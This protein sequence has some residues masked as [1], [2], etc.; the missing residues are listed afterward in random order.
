[1]LLCLLALAGASTLLCAAAESENKPFCSWTCAVFTLQWPGAFC[2]SLDDTSL[3][4]LLPDVNSWLIHGLW[5]QKIQQCCRCWNMFASDV[6]DIRGPL[7]EKWPSLLTSRSSLRF[8]KDEWEKHGACAGCVEGLNSP[9]AYF[10][11]CLKLRQRFDLQKALEDA[12]VTPSCQRPYKLAEVQKALLPLAGGDKMEIQ[13]IKDHQEREVWFQ[14]KIQLS[15]NMSLGCPHDSGGGGSSGG[16]HHDGKDGG[17]SSGGHPCP[18]GEAF[19]YV[20]I[21]H[22]HPLRPCG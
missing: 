17:S 15:R 3:C 2:Q 9:L 6:Q 12:G 10:S 1:M 22:Q 20:P 19:Y 18:D 7:E 16:R 11:T 13:C 8:W 14:T 21:D 5:P 4:K